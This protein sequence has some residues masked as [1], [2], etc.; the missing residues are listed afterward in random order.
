MPTQPTRRQ[1]MQVASGLAAA[2]ILPCKLGLAQDNREFLLS[3]SELS[4]RRLLESK[5]IEHLDFVVLAKNEF[6]IAAV[7]YASP[8]FSGRATDE[9]FLDEMNERAADQGVR[10]LLIHVLEQVRIGDAD[11]T[12]RQAALQS[13]RQWIDA[14]KMLG[15][16]SIVVDVAPDDAAAGQQARVV[17]GLLALCEYGERQRINVLINST[18]P[19]DPAGLLNLIKLVKR[20]SCGTYL[21][22]DSIVGNSTPDKVAGLMP[23]TRGVSATSSEFDQ[24]GNEKNR[25]FFRLMNLILEAGYRG[26]VG[27]EYRGNKLPEREGIGATKALLERVRAQRA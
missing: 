1:F 15:C 16:H 3:L 12:R 10:Q 24:Q 21:C 26:Y 19:T 25:D 22:F 13:H 23:I 7:E 8:F 4:L 5:E 18:A 17:E 14:A 2:A 20:P 27:I 6:G 11:A 9:K